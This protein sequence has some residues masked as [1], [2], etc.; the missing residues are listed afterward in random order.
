M[1]I[2][3]I[4]RERRLAKHLTQEQVA[5]YL[6]VTT[7]AVN[8]WEKGTSYPDIT[9]LPALARL[10]DTDLNTLLSFQEELT[11]KEI[12]LFL[13]HLTELAEKS[14][15]ET[16]YAAA[17]EKLRE[18]PSCYPLILNV[19]V[20][21][22]GAILLHSK[23]ESAGEYRAAVESLYQRALSSSDQKIQNGAYSMLISRYMERKEYDKAQELLN[24]L[25]EEA[26]VDKKQL[27]AKL[28]IACGKLDEAAK[29]EEETLLSAG[30]DIYAVLMTLMEIAIKENRMDDAEYIANVSKKSAQ[31]LDLW[32]YST[33]VAHFQLYS[34]SKNSAKCLKVLVPMLRSLTQN[35]DISK[36]PLYRHVQTKAAERGF[37]AK[38]RKSLIQSMSKDENMTFLQEN[39]AFQELAQKI[40]QEDE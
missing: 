38:L 29:L 11:E 24:Q 4:I 22:D 10:L 34:A 12:T 26:P 9:L 15:F 37:G 40:A 18:Y 31:T 23:K 20:F 28:L 6:G 3:E 19:A 1:K 36:S 27:Q 17:M 30:N 16:A 32:E 2:H 13:N 21:L 33:Y 39:E 7:P 8:K 25:P 5:N 35:W 14:G